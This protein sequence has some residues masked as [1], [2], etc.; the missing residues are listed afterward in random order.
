VKTTIIEMRQAGV[1]R[2]KGS[3]RGAW[4][5]KGELEIV[6]TRENSYNR[7]LKMAILRNDKG[8][9]IKTL[10]NVS[11]L[12]L[13]DDRLGLTGFERVLREGELVDY[14]QSWV[15]RID[16]QESGRDNE[17]LKP[18]EYNFRH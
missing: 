12:W 17:H 10:Y 18:R 1:A 3:L 9:S 14:A 4:A 2:P 6:D 5:H 13:T 15:C 11:I 16:S 7:I 8:E